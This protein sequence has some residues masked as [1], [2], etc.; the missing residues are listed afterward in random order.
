MNWMFAQFG[1]F[2]KKFLIVK[3]LINKKHLNT[4]AQTT[5]IFTPTISS[6]FI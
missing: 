5:N 6:V 4:V 1:K 3:K 2:T